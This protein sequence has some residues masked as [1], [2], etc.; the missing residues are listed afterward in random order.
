MTA[1]NSLGEQAIFIFPQKYLQFKKLR[2]SKLPVVKLELAR[3]PQAFATL[4]NSV[5]VN[6]PFPV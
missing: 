1:R 5:Y 3:F 4:T 6:H 2:A